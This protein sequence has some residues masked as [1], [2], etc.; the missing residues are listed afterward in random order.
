[1]G[2]V[3]PVT[4]AGPTQLTGEAEALRRY[5]L[6]DLLD[7]LAGSTDP[8]ESALIRWH[9]WIGA[10]ERA[11]AAGG[12]WLGTGKWLLRE[13]RAA[14]PVLAARLTAAVGDQ[15]LLAPVAEQ[16]LARCGGPLRAGSRLDG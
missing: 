2:P 12:H 4:A 9:V 5:G 13:L 8:G 11:L 14:D 7:D 6:T 10:A 3:D 1:M 16:V 15:V